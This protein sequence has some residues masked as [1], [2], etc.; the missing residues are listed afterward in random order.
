MSRYGSQSLLHAYSKYTE[1]WLPVLVAT[2]V[3]Y[4]TPRGKL[5]GAA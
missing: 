2:Y 1:S 4:V 3:P 5:G